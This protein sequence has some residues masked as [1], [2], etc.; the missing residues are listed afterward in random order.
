MTFPRKALHVTRFEARF[1]SDCETYDADKCGGLISEGERAG[2]IGDDA[3]GA[4]CEDCCDAAED[5]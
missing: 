4:S 3:A 1:E 2:Y 5:A